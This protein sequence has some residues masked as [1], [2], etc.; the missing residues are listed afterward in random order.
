MLNVRKQVAAL[1]DDKHTIK[2][3]NYR[4]ILVFI[5]KVECILARAHRC[6]TKMKITSNKLLNI[7]FFFK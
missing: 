5:K 3:K 4:F 7:I 1:I 2:A 6:T